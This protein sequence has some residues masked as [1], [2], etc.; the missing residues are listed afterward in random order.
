MTPERDLYDAVMRDTSEHPYI[1][2]ARL[3]RNVV[4]VELDA[5]GRIE[6]IQAVRP[7]TGRGTTFMRWLTV[8]AD[9]CGATL[10]GHCEPCSDQSPP[11]TTLKRWY[12][13]HGFKVRTTG[14][15]VRQPFVGQQLTRH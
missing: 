12:E 11:F 14:N 7:N 1:H 4:T 13:S 6:M 2:G 15:M 8:L 10:T 3:W 5:S 9:H